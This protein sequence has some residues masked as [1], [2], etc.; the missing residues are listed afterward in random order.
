MAV[1]RWSV[2]RIRLVEAGS[3]DTCGWGLSQSETGFAIELV[4]EA[5][6]MDPALLEPLFH[7][8]CLGC[9]A[10]YDWDILVPEDDDLE[11]QWPEEVAQQAEL[12]ET[13]QAMLR[14]PR[15]RSRG[16]ARLIRRRFGVEGIYVQDGS[17]VSRPLQRLQ[18]SDFLVQ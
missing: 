6:F 13:L 10:R 11:R 1:Q 16:V 2:T 4:V 12:H 17:E 14:T 15:M 8:R 9:G 3:C 18:S 7:R 5:L